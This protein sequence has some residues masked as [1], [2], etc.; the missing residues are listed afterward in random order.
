MPRVAT[1]TE[2]TPLSR[3]PRPEDDLRWN[4]RRC[5]FALFLAI[6]PFVALFISRIHLATTTA[7]KKES[8]H[9][10]TLP[11]DRLGFGEDIAPERVSITFP[12]HTS[13]LLENTDRRSNNNG[14]LRSNNGE[15]KILPR[16]LRW[17]ILGPGACVLFHSVLSTTVR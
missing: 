12:V 6:P 9:V 2:A 5:L 11:S 14:S 13:Y 16:S 1:V 7:R 15:D 8:D 4:R 17:A 10:V 3:P